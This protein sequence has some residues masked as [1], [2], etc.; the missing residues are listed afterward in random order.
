MR[1]QDYPPQEP[2]SAVA[3]PYRD[4]CM[5]M[6]S[7]VPFQEFQYGTDPYQSIAIYAPAKPDGRIF[8]FIHGGGWVSGYKEWMSFMAPA[9]TAHGITFASIGYRLAPKH[10]FPAAYDDCAL[11]VQWLW[12]NA[13]LFKADPKRLAIGGHSAG[14][15]YGALLAVKRDWQAGLGLPNDV[16]KLCLPISGVFRFGEGSGL[17]MRPR[18]LGPEGNGLETPASPVLNIQGVPPPFFVAYGT[19]DFPHLITQGAEMVKVLGA[20]GS[21]VE[22]MVMEGRD[23]FAASFAGGEADGPWVPAA[24]NWLRRL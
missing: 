24:L 13:G 18:F 21:E 8:A 16:I 19:K 1:P 17:S 4:A 10:I 9:F 14:G 5:M 12:K 3:T 15:H 6:S 22:H 11:A 20:A 2:V 7:G 23:H